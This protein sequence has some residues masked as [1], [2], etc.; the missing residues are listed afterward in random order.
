MDS[1]LRETNNR[2]T[3]AESVLR[4]LG[5]L[6]DKFAQRH[7]SLVSCLQDLDRRVESMDGSAKSSK[8]IDLEARKAPSPVRARPGVGEL[9]PL[10]TLPEEYIMPPHTRPGLGGPAGTSV[11]AT[12]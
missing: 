10:P 6:H 9:V 4:E 5:A 2:V 8:K 12:V 7:D 1:K 11:H 3:Q